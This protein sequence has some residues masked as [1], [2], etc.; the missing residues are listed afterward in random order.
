MAVLLTVITANHMGDR[1]VD[2]VVTTTQSCVVGVL[3]G[4]AMTRSS[5]SSLLISMRPLTLSSP[6]RHLR[7]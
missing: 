6:L 1:H 7:V 4:R 3:S 5:S 2:V